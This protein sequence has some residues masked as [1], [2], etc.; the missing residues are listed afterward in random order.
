LR[1]ER[2]GSHR[3][4]APFSRTL[5]DLLAEQ[6]GRYGDALAVVAGDR[7]TSYRHLAERS[8]RV[9]AALHAQ[10][11]RH[12]DRVALL[13][14]NRA[15]WLEFCFGSAAVG[16]VLA[17]FSTWSTRAE[18]DFLLRDSR[19]RLL[20]LSNRFGD[21]D[22]AADI[23]ALVP[24]SVQARSGGWRSVRFPDLTAIIL[25]DGR[26]A[27][28]WHDYEAFTAVEPLAAALPPGESAAA[29]DDAYLLYTSGSSNRPKAVRLVHAGVI[30]NGFN[31]GERQGLKPGDRVLLAPP[32]FWSYGG[33]NALPATL[34][35][36]AT[37]VLQPKF[38]AGEAIALVE[39]HRCTAIYTLPG[40]TA[41]MARHPTYGPER[42]SS[43]RTGVTIGAPA[44]IAE[45]IDRLGAT[46]L[47]NIYGST[48]TYG[49]CCVTWHYWPRE[50]RAACQGPPLPGIAIR[51]V[52]EATR[53]PVEDSEIG[54]VE[55]AGYVTPGYA[56]ASASLNA[57]AFTEDGF[58][59]TG[60][61]GRMNLDGSFT[62]IG[63]TAEMIKK[64]G[65][66][67]SPAEVEEILLTHPA[68]AQ[69]AVVGAPDAEKGEVVIAFV[70]PV[71]GAKPT[72]EDLLRH[73]RGLI[74]KYKV[75]DHIEF[76]GALPFTVTGKLQ[77]SAL[78][79]D[80][81]SVVAGGERP[82]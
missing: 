3:M 69:A 71:A 52:D 48:E 41:A 25:V 45:A 37:L 49:N 34:T 67:V 44:E 9:A 32:L 15:E 26:P 4:R 74:S 43:L 16:A 23:A 73:C 36:G 72:V 47:C 64:A 77:R 78:K 21:R 61:I 1:G 82:Q 6:A 19:A 54:L 55:V 12:G 2:R 66:N 79:A 17:P 30:E 70:V 31:I 76:R 40:M 58:F 10:G 29:G 38:E 35:H 7:S 39:R 60:D 20:V 28:G 75:P 53:K 18:L 81:Q 27:A 46:E 62:Y 59:R 11:I 50:R 13:M 24:E 51:I 42:L 57:E 80:A 65:I 33:A 22:F 5:A 56:G 63:R 68:I 14:E 8:S